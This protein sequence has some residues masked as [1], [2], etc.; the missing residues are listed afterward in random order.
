MTI[1]VIQDRPLL[2]YEGKYYSLNPADIEKYAKLCDRLIYCASAIDCS[3]EKIARATCVESNNISVRILNKAPLA[4][5][6]WPSKLNRE[7]V[8][9][10]I[11]DADVVVVKV[12]SFTIG[13][14]AIN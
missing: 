8:T 3:A 2:R 4:E 11:N 14:L 9:E 7:V 12:P 1:S 5:M 6:L 13:K 10:S